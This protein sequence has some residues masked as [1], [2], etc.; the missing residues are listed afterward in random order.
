MPSWPS[1]KIRRRGSRVLTMEPGHNGLSQRVSYLEP[2]R[3]FRRVGRHQ[4]LRR[5]Q[6]DMDG[7]RSPGFRGGRITAPFHSFIRACLSSSPTADPSGESHGGFASRTEVLGCGGLAEFAGDPGDVAE[8]CHL[9]RS[10]IATPRDRISVASRGLED[11]MADGV[12]APGQD[13]VRLAAT[14]QSAGSAGS[15]RPDVKTCIVPS[16]ASSK[17]AIRM[18]GRAQEQEFERATTIAGENWTFVRPGQFLGTHGRQCE[19]LS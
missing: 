6:I 15:W 18:H 14:R 3:I 10:L 19:R 1:G 2:R 17:A 9:S 13:Q 16:V 8:H 4:G 5:S 11:K 12:D 7:Q